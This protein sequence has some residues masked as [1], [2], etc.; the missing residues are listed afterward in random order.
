MW[1]SM[2]HVDVSLAEKV[3]RPMLIYAFL[4]VALRVA[5]KRE[6]AQL[7]SLDFVVLLAVAN[8]VQNGIIGNDNS[9]TGGVLGASTLFLLNGLLA[10]ALFHH[11]RLRRLVE[12][13]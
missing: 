9:V 6:M 12:G 11:A 8:A 10:F 7:N 5:G 1:H 3:V 4:V 13:S 2:F